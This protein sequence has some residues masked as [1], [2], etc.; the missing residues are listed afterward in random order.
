MTLY[1]FRHTA[2]YWSKIAKFIHPTCGSNPIKISQRCLVLGK[3]KWLSIGVNFLQIVGA[4]GPFLPLPFPSLSSLPLPSPPSPPL[5]SPLLRNR[6][7]QTVA[8]EPV[9]KWDGSTASASPPLPSLPFPSPPL[10]LPLPLLSHPFPLPFPP[11]P[12]EVGPLKSS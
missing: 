2:K 1:H 6:A 4:H 5:P 9:E 3:L 11:L 12:L 8:S 10:S 7:P